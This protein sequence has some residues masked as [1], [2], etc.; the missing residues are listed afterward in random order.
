M[1][2]HKMEY[3]K[4]VKRWRVCLQ[5]DIK[6]FQIYIVKQK[7]TVAGKKCKCMP[8]VQHSSCKKKYIKN[9]LYITY[10]CKRNTQK[11]NEKLMT[12]IIWWSRCG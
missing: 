5:T 2:H 10:L 9:Y 11:I 6:W 12:L 4:A 3:Y 1:V 7:Q 8:I